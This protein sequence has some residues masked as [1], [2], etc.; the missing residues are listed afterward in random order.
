MT[1]VYTDHFIIL[2]WWFYY[3]NFTKKSE[4]S[5]ST[6]TDDMTDHMHDSS[7]RIW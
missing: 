4:N 2:K 7:N 5:L 1:I 3:L 6:G